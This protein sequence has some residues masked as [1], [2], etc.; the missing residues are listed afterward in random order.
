VINQNLG[1]H[2][3]KKIMWSRIL[4]GIGALLLACYVGGIIYIYNICEYSQYASVG[5]DIDALIHSVLL[6]PLAIICL[7]SSLVLRIFYKK[8]KK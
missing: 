5:A 7:V 8:S 3:M 6:L 2:G 1:V 4:L